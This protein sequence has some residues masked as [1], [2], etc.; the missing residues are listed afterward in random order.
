[1]EDEGGGEEWKEESRW[2]SGRLLSAVEAIQRK[3]C[4]VQIGRIQYGTVHIR[5]LHAAT[6]RGNLQPNATLCTPYI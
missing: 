2:K 5:Y 1:M 4:L 6:K 3:Y